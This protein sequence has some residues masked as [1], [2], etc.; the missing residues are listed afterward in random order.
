MISVK[1]NKHSAIARFFSYDDF[2]ELILQVAANIQ[3]EETPWR[4]SGK[5]PRYG[6]FVAQRSDRL[7]GV[8]TCATQY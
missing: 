7:P 1:M 3:T 5:H 8:I 2:H 6:R 4:V